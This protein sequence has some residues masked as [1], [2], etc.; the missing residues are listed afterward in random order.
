MGVGAPPSQPVDLDEIA[1][2]PP[3]LVGQE[4]TVGGFKEPASVVHDVV[5]GGGW[6]RLSITYPFELSSP[7]E[8][9]YR[10]TGIKTTAAKLMAEL[11]NFMGAPPSGGP[12]VSAPVFR[13]AI[14]SEISVS[15]NP[16]NPRT[17]IAFDLSRSG[18]VTLGLAA[19][20]DDPSIRGGLETEMEA[21]AA[22]RA[23]SMRPSM[24][25]DIFKGRRTE[26]DFINGLVVERGADR[27]PKHSTSSQTPVPS[28]HLPD[29]DSYTQAGYQ[30][31]TSHSQVLL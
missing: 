7:F 21:S 31:S 1:A 16:F 4:F 22:N 6:K 8:I 3:A 26:I 24:G 28:S 13:D 9:T 17:R 29:A 15:P 23:E 18:T 19:A 11:L 20:D 27:D 5:S 30:G 14:L 2:I 10:G 25:Q 12:A